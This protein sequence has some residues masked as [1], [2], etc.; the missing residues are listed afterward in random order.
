MCVSIGSIGVM[1]RVF[2][3][4]WWYRVGGILMVGGFHW[5]MVVGRR[6]CLV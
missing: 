1:V 6:G 2:D 3:G 5:L 4:H